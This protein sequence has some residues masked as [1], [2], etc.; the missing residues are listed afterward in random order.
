[1]WKK[2][3]A[4]CLLAIAFTTPVMASDEPLTLD[5]IDLVPEAERKLFDSVGMPASDHSGS[6]AQQSKIGNVRPE[7][8]GSQVKIPGFVIPLEGDANTVTEFLLVPYFGACIHVPPPPPNQIIYVK[9]PKGAPVQELWDVIYVVGTLKT[10]T[11]NH[12]LAETAY[13]IE[14]S[15]IEAYDDM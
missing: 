12:E 13:V 10:E 5:W 2:V 1:M 9:F 8:N 11:I 3:L 7:L 4:S 6:A 15:K 14:G